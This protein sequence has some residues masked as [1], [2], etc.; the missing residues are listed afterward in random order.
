MEGRMA[1]I[2][3]VSQSGDGFTSATPIVAMCE[4][5]EQLFLATRHRVYKLVRGVWCPMVLADELP[6]NA[7][8]E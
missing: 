2:P 8:V 5:Q 7:P 1:L 6:I 4:H 3:A